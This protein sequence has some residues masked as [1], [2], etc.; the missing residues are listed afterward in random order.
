[1]WDYVFKD[2]ILDLGLHINEKYESKF[3]H[4]ILCAELDFIGR[5]ENLQSDFNYICEQI[6]LEALAL[7]HLEKTEHGHYHKFYNDE[8]RDLV[9]KIYQKD[10]EL[11][12]YEF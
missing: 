6:G 7:P 8:T 1:M 5:F 12:K 4:E 3:Y 9:S 2:F 10:I 11:F